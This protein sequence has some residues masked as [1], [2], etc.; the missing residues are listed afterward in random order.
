[1]SFVWK[2]V[3]CNKILPFLVCSRWCFLVMIPL[4]FFFFFFFLWWGRFFYTWLA[5]SWWDQRIAE[6]LRQSQIMWPCW[7]ASDVNKAR[8]V[9]MFETFK[10]EEY[11]KTVLV[12][13]VLF[14][15][16]Y[17]KFVLLVSHILKTPSFTEFLLV[18]WLEN[19]ILKHLPWYCSICP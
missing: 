3:F 15:F 2:C 19:C 10:T 13:S 4:P 6:L 7:T 5:Y 8:Q 14:F 9:N 16:L 18:Y 17:W 11:A 1:M 12:Y